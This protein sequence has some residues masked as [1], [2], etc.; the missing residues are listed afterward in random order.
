MSAVVEA[1]G[2][3][4]GFL[5]A[6][7]HLSLRPPFARLDS[8]QTVVE[9]GDEGK[10]TIDNI[11]SDTEVVPAPAQPEHPMSYPP[12]VA[13]VVPSPETIPESTGLRRLRMFSSFVTLFLAG[14]K[15]VQLLRIAC[16]FGLF[17]DRP[18][19]IVAVALPEHCCPTLKKHTTSTMPE[20]P[21]YSSAPSWDM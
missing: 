7:A 6:E 12:T 9:R 5:E 2:A 14:W 17:T 15:S 21:C 1:S 3:A 11:P 16:E 4:H 19:H 8:A 20:C 13:V 18:W 10:E